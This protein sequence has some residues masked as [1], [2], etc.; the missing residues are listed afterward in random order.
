MEAAV[1]LVFTGLNAWK[2]TCRQGLIGASCKDQ[3]AEVQ[4]YTRRLP[5]FLTQLRGF[6]NSNEPGSM[7]P[8]CSTQVVEL[9]R[10]VK[11]QAAGRAEARS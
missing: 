5:P 11:A 6:V 1:T 7:P 4:I 8:C 2:A 9:I 3:I 10:T